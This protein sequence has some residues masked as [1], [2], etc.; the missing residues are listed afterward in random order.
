MKKSILIVLLFAGTFIV[1]S[2]NEKES[3]KKALYNYMEGTAN[4]EP[5]RVKKAFH[6][7]LNLY[8]VRNGEL[9]V[10]NGNKYIGN[11]KQ[12][13]KSNRIGKIISIDFE[14]NAA[15]AKLE[16]DMPGAKRVYTDYMLLLK[17]KGE[18]KVIHKSY[19]FKPYKK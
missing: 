13:R 4:G 18:W 3:I 11:I 6:K 9:N 19:T 1:N 10:W 12:G 14:N 7:D 17:I 8:S 5:E 2:Q 15:M 16:I